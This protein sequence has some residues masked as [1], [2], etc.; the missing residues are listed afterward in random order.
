MSDVRVLCWLS[1]AAVNVMHAQW[2][3]G[4][5][6][7]PLLS[8]AYSTAQRGKAD[9][10]TMASLRMVDGGRWASSQ[11]HSR[12]TRSDTNKSRN[13]FSVVF[14]LALL[15]LLATTLRIHCCVGC[16]CHRLTN[17]IVVIVI[18]HRASCTNKRTFTLVFALR[19]HIYVSKPVLY[20]FFCELRTWW[21]L[22]ITPKQIEA[23]GE[24]GEWRT[25]E[26]KRGD[27]ERHNDFKEF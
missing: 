16:R 15:L 22:V 6:R 10:R 20:L 3:N 24:N 23:N 17:G 4:A 11:A 7:L 13:C 1:G 27:G 14:L 2:A 21:L 8:I 25:V 12:P 18:F 26:A 9:S 5:V 19:T